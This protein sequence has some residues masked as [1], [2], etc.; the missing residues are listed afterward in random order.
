MHK[1]GGM[2]QHFLFR[3]PFVTARN[4]ILPTDSNRD[5]KFYTARSISV[6]HNS[7]SRNVIR[8]NPIN[9]YRD[10]CELDAIS[11]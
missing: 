11:R 2:L 4:D 1:I 3:T 9:A 6:T 7:V 10:N 5:D 8:E